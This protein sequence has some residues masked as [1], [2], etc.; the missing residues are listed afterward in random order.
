M[1][2]LLLGLVAWAAQPESYLYWIQPCA[3][4]IAEQSGCEASDPE[5]AAW[6]VEAWQRA[7]EGRFTVSRTAEENKA[8]IRI[9]WVAGP[10]GMYGEARPIL[11]EGRPGAEVYVRPNLSQLGRE[12]DLAGRKDRLFRHAIVYLTCLH[13]TGHALGLSHTAAFEDIMYYFGYGGDIV[14][15]F[16]RYRRKLAS[17]ADIRKTPGISPSDQ[18][19]LAARHQKP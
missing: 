1:K 17:R 4:E 7:G 11:V 13:E 5:L 3:G 10:A 12:I 2:Y 15:Y 14:E 18:A 9:Y 8:R 16:A 6:A 19:R